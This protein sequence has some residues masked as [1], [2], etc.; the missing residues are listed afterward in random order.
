MG[1]LIFSLLI[2][3]LFEIART[4]SERIVLVVVK[5]E[6]GRKSFLFVPKV[7]VDHPFVT[8]VLTQSAY[9]NLLFC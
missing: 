1:E 4:F 7:F 3:N 8:L 6:F 9:E 5:C 2:L